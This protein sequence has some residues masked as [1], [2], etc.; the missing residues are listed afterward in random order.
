MT[1]KN[2]QK[3][4]REQINEG[5]GEEDKTASEMVDAGIQ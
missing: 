1:S 2:A 3:C 4:V 5:K